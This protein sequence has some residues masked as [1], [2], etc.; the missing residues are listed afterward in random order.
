MQ[1]EEGWSE[2]QTFCQ[3]CIVFF[4]PENQV[5]FTF[6]DIAKR[7]S[8]RLSKTLITQEVLD[9]IHGQVGD[10]EMIYCEKL[11]EKV[12]VYML[13]VWD[14]LHHFVGK[15]FEKR[16]AELYPEYSIVY[17]DMMYHMGHIVVS[18]NNKTPFSKYLERM[19]NLEESM[20][21]D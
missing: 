1:F 2:Y 15:I 3:P 6:K 16:L 4:D 20:L 13:E 19:V 17:V 8:S 5:E 14:E 18:F 12:D 10:K 21:C 7:I 9:E 11:V